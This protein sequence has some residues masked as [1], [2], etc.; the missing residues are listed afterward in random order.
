MDRHL[1]SIGTTVGLESGSESTK[2]DA[3]KRYDKAM[4]WLTGD[5]EQTGRPR[6]DI[7]VEKQEKY[8]KAVDAKTKAF[9]VALARAKT[10]PANKT[11]AQQRA[12]YDIWV[13]ENTRTYR[14]FI[15][16][17]YMDWVIAGK[18]EAVEYYFSIVDNDT[19]MARVEN[20]KVCRCRYAPLSRPN[21]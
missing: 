1:V 11:V 13:S 5:D 15:Q 12:A 8:T 4:T 9:D 21:L 14:N 17:A 7:Y 3:Q 20:S 10:D 19:A 6:I 16:A 2:S 18:K